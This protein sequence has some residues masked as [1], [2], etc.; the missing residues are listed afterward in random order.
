[1]KIDRG[2]VECSTNQV[3]VP[4]GRNS[5]L[6]QFAHR[7]SKH[8]LARL[9]AKRAGSAVAALQ[10]LA[11]AGIPAPAWLFIH[12]AANILCMF[13]LDIMYYKQKTPVTL[14]L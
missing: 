12:V 1:V 4:R 3:P 10:G 2:A 11:A 8:N 9:P 14:S 5:G 13:A 6:Q 7:I